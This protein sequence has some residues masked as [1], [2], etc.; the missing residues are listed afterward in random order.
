MKRHLIKKKSLTLLLAVYCFLGT[1]ETARANIIFEDLFDRPPYPNNIIGNGW[2]KTYN[3][4]ADV[5]LRG[6]FASG[7]DGI[8]WLRDINASVTHQ[9]STVGFMNISLS[10]DWRGN[11]AAESGDYLRLS[12]F[13]GSTSYDSGLLLPLANQTVT[14]TTYDLPASAANLPGFAF[15]FF[16]NVD[17]F[18]EA[19][20]IQ[21]V[22]LTGDII[23]APGAILLGSIGVGLVGWLRRR[24]SL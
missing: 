13:D 6:R 17:M 23:P 10:F 18:N 2:T 19:A 9:D 12:W 22:T 7:P 8:L 14:T 3:Q 20:R 11:A 15:T 21:K 5:Q 4:Y 24:R 16:T 1:M